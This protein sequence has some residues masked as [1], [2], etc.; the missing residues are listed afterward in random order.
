MFIQLP[1]VDVY[2]IKST[3]DVM[4]MMMPHHRMGK[5]IDCYINIQNKSHNEKLCI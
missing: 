2:T 1:V 4:P 5:M 3:V